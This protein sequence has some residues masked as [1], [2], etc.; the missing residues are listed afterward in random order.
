MEICVRKYMFGEKS[1]FG[2]CRKV[3]TFPKKVN[4]DFLCFCTLN[5]DQIP[6]HLM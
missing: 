2:S 5:K 3:E 6:T 1:T 4:K